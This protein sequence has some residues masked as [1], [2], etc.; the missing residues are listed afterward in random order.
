MNANKTVELTVFAVRSTGFDPVYAECII[1]V[2]H[3]YIS[4]RLSN[5]QPK[6]TCH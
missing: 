2:G 4:L 1:I 3:G 5:D 6:G